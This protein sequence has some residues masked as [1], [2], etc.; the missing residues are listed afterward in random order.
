MTNSLPANADITLLKKQAKKLLKQYRSDNADALN[1]VNTF[2]PKPESFTGLRDAHLVIARSYGFKGWA[3]LRN[4]VAKKSSE[5]DRLLYCDF[6]GRSQHEVRK[7]IAGPEVFICDIC[8]DLCIGII[9]EEIQPEEGEVLKPGGMPHLDAVIRKSQEFNLPKKR[10][11]PKIKTTDDTKSSIDQAYHNALDN[12][13][14]GVIL[15]RHQG[16]F[17]LHEASGIAN[18]RQKTSILS[19]PFLTLVL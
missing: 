5:K 12:G 10:S 11:T 3:E 13:F 8:A 1:T 19:I 14:S 18:R 9:V 15:V 7:L 4:G 16:D 17:V 2:H 6:C